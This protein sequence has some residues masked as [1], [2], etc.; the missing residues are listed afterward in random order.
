M[1]NYTNVLLRALEQDLSQPKILVVGDVM[2]DQYWF[3]Q[4][5]RI[6]PEAPI[7]IANAQSTE[8][9]LGGSA[10]VANNIL[11]LGGRASILSSI[12]NDNDG[13]DL[14]NLLRVN[15]ITSLMEIDHGTTTKK[16]RIVAHQQ[17]LLRID[18]ERPPTE[19]VLQNMLN[20]YKQQ[21]P[22]YDVIIFSDYNK[23]NLRDISLMIDLAYRSGKLTIVDPKGTNYQKY[24][25]TDI[26]T[27]NVA[28]LKQFIGSWSNEQDLLQRVNLFKKE[29]NCKYLLLT[30]S[31]QGMSLF[32]ANSVEH[33]PVIA[34]QVYDVSGAGDTVIATLALLLA[35]NIEINTAVYA[36]NI[37]ASIVVSK[38]GTATTN[39]QEL[40][41]YL[42]NHE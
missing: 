32:Y 18:F 40:I 9:R 39:Q 30:R 24:K 22:L 2:L 31:E 20:I 11:K 26:I 27:P 37:T 33:Y 7:P 14:L 15:H 41:K 35:N 23:G 29:I 13:N 28:E 6:S 17:Q 34:Q 25:N 1:Y 16:L 8:N 38:A 4:V 21:L 10:N 19:Q 12:G 3:T 42:K 36:S 5:S